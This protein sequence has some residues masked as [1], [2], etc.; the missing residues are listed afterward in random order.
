[1]RNDLTDNNTIRTTDGIGEAAAPATDISRRQAALIDLSYEPIFVWG[2]ETGITEWNTGAERLYGYSRDEA[3]GRESHRLL[4]TI[5]PLPLRKYLEILKTEGFWSGELRHQTKDGR[6][7]F[8]ESRQQLVESD[9]RRLILE[10]NRDITERYVE[11]LRLTLLS[12]PICSLP[13]QKLW[14]NTLRP[15]D[16]FSMRSTWK[17]TLRRCIAIFAAGPSR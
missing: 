17:M 9:G 5:S 16:A 12:P 6:E 1:M 10:T 7:V 4:Q 8:V 3:I 11:T 13:C 14:A 2:L 15:D